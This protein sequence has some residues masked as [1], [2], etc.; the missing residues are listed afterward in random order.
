PVAHPA[1]DG[2]VAYIH[3]DR[4]E[5]ARCLDAF[6]PGDGDAWRALME[7]WDR[8]GEHVLGALFTPFP[9][10]K[11]GAKLVGA[12]GYKGLVDFARFG[13]L[14]VRRLADEDFRGAGGPRLIA[15]NS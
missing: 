12:L 3:P 2:T 6:A 14:P 13:L 4:D 7:R 9:P 11:A 15:G 8:A 5:T 1:R 10:V